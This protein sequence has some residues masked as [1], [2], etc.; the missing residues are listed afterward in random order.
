MSIVRCVKFVALVPTFD[1]NPQPKPYA[2]DVVSDIKFN[3]DGPFKPTCLLINEMV[4]AS[5][6]DLVIKGNTF[7]L[8]YCANGDTKL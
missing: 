4:R 7:W 3:V 6:K 2:N 5:N 8:V 1:V